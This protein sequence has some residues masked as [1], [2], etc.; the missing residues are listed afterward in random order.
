M[1]TKNEV[2]ISVLLLTLLVSL[3]NPFGLWMPDEILYLTIGG[4]FVLVSIFSS[5]VWKESARDEREQL[6]KMIAGRFGYL[7]GMATLL[8]GIIIESIDSHPSPWLISAVAAM[9]LGK[10]FGAHWAKLKR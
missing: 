3:L 9:V 4:V 7:A 1:E 2:I 5:F 8:L 10:I 6:H